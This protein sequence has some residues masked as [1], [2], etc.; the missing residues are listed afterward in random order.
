MERWI[1]LPGGRHKITSPFGVRVHPVTGEQAFH[2]GA[3]LRASPRT[4][5]ICPLQGYVRRCYS[6]EVGGLQLVLEHPDGW[7]TGYAH[8][9]GY[10]EGIREGAAVE[11]GQT[12]AYSGNSGR[13]TGPHLHL[14]VR[15]GRDYVDPATVLQL[16]DD[17]AG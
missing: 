16:D 12:I 7:R 10:G 9:D 2:N 17:H 4:P 5:V 13:S 15:H 1:V 8:L 14:T 3:D 6:S 11:P